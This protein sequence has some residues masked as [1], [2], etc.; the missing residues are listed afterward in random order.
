MSGFQP[1]GTPILYYVDPI[2]PYESKSSGFDTGGDASVTDGSAS[3]TT[4]ASG[5]KDAGMAD[6]RAQFQEM[7]GDAED[8]QERERERHCGIAVPRKPSMSE[9]EEH[10]L[11]G[12]AAMA[13]EQPPGPTC[14]HHISRTECPH[15]SHPACNRA[16]G[17][18]QMHARHD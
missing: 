16:S 17:S 11:T 1:T 14:H 6:S 8:A 15:G 13:L 3:G 10:N 18:W 2:S 9:V 12:P 4:R 5:S 7:Q